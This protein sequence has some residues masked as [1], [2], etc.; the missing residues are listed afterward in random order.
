MATDR[1]SLHRHGVTMSPRMHL[2]H[3]YM[4]LDVIQRY[5]SC[6]F[7]SVRGVEWSDGW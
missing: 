6:F 5:R 1:S 2:E 7:S 3:T 4:F